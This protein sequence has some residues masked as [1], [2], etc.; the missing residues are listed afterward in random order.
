[1]SDIDEI[2]FSLLRGQQN[3]QK[4]LVISTAVLTNN[5]G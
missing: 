4:L 2:A 1:M 5:I 3:Q